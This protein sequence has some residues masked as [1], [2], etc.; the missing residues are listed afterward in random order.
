MPNTA[1]EVLLVVFGRRPVSD[2]DQLVTAWRAQGGDKARA[3]YEQLLAN[4]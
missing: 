4:H 1:R 3:E 2:L